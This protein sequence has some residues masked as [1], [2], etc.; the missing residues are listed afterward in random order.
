[1]LRPGLSFRETMRGTLW[2]LDAPTQERAVD[3]TLEARSDDLRG[4]ARDQT[5]RLRGTVD[6]EGLA[7]HADAGGTL[8]FK[9]ATERRLPYRVRFR[10]DD[11]RS[12][13]LS[14]QKEWLPVSP[15]ESVT[16]LPA[17]LYDEDGQ[18]IGRATLRFDLRVDGWHFL[19]SFRLHLLG[20]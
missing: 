10:G 11:G 14:G 7:T 15:I 18:E 20:R 4:L 9:L 12:Y 6:V 19:T 2:L 5:F 17:S 1:V 16:T 3:V 13:E 8:V